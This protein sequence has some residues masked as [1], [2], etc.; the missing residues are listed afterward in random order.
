MGILEA[1]ACFRWK[2]AERICSVRFEEDG[3]TTTNRKTQNWECTH[4]CV[5][6]LPLLQL[7]IE[8][9]IQFRRIGWQED[10]DERR[11]VGESSESNK[12]FQDI[13]LS[14]FFEQHF[15]ILFHFIYARFAISKIHLPAFF[16]AQYTRSLP[17]SLGMRNCIFNIFQLLYCNQCGVCNVC[18]H[19]YDSTVVALIHERCVHAFGFACCPFEMHE[20]KVFFWVSEQ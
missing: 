15:T 16:D 1:V 17:V 8:H 10:K 4:A 11:K 5:Q 2:N 19:L 18:M 7:W 6:C 13:F 9:G 12:V 14:F 20:R 3:T